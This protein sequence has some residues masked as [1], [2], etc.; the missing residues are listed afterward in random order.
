MLFVCYCITSDKS[1][2]PDWWDRG[3]VHADRLEAVFPSQARSHT[4]AV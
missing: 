3:S 4:Q 1:R 2:V